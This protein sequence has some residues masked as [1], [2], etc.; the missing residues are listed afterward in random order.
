MYSILILFFSLRN[1][2]EK[3]HEIDSRSEMQHQL[4]VLQTLLLKSYDEKLFSGASFEDA[5]D[6]VME[7]RNNYLLTMERDSFDPNRNAFKSTTSIA[8][9]SSGSSNLSDKNYCEDFDRL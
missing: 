7:I 2:N 5:R 8:S 4:Y 1:D 6:K 9:A 3:A